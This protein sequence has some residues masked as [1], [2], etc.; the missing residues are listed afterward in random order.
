MNE[1]YDEEVETEIY[2]VVI[3]YTEPVY[4]TFIIQADSEET[5]KERITQSSDDQGYENL[6][7]ISIRMMDRDVDGKPKV[8]LQ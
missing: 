2:E 6:K 8:T 3:S 7:F 1:E 5:I 4:A